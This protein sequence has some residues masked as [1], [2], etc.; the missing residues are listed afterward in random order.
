MRRE[1]TDPIAFPDPLIHII[2]S[3][4]TTDFRTT[5]GDQSRAPVGG[6]SP[7]QTEDLNDTRSEIWLARLPC[8]RYHLLMLNPG[9]GVR[10]MFASGHPGRENEQHLGTRNEPG[11]ANQSHSGGSGSALLRGKC[12]EILLTLGGH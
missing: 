12:C 1:R 11:T 6:T 9:N 5:R 4:I 10:A 7:H 8:H 3:S 2:G